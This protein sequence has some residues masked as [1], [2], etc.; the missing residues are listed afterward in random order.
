MKGLATRLLRA[1][2]RTPHA[3]VSPSA[4]SERD[5]V[6]VNGKELAHLHP[7]RG[8][9]VEVDLRLGRARIRE[10]AGAD[11]RLHRR[12]SSGDW[13]EMHVASIADV[14][15]AARWFALAAADH[16]PLAGTRPKEPP[17]GA[18]LARRRRF[19]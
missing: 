12:S 19:H 8:G 6:C 2:A 17:T 7:A 14:R 18:D 9:A 16:A 3:V 5:A 1:L 13:V 15:D 4:F 10:L 11:E